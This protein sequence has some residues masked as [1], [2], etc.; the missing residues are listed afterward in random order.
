MPPRTVSI[1]D[2]AGVDLLMEVSAAAVVALVVG[3][4][5]FVPLPPSSRSVWLG[6]IGLTV[7]G[8]VVAILIDLH[9]KAE[10]LRRGV[11][12]S[13]RIVDVSQGAR[14]GVFVSVHVTMGSVEVDAP[15]QPLGSWSKPQVGQS[16]KVLA[17]PV[18]GWP[19]ALLG[20]A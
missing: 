16:V 4:F 11:L 2:L 17:D 13:G 3:V 20:P 15:Q 10:A 9:Q 12:A 1:R 14:G 6:L 5:V 18:T 8:F 19:L 7:V